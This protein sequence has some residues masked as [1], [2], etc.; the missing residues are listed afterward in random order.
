MNGAEQSCAHVAKLTQ[1]MCEARP[2]SYWFILF[3][4]K[5]AKWH[6]NN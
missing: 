3:N 2:V 1:S 6:W 5:V 4:K